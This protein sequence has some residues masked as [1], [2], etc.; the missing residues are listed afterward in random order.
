MA[1]TP[2]DGVDAPDVAVSGAKHRDAVGSCGHTFGH[3]PTVI[4][5]TTAFA[6]VDGRPVRWEE[7]EVRGGRDWTVEATI[8]PSLTLESNR[9]SHG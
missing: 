1:S 9:A 8:Q 2:G 6:A 4:E 5:S 3:W 7:L